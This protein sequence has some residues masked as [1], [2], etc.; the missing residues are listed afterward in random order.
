MRHWLFGMCA[1]LGGGAAQGQPTG[2]TYAKVGH[3][4]ISAGDEKQCSMTQEFGSI[5]E[6]DVQVV[7]VVYDA[8][9]E[10]VVL[11][12]AGKRPKYLL[13]SGSVNLDLGF[14][15]DPA[16]TETWSSKR[17][18]Y[19]KSGSTYYLHHVVMGR[20]DAE[21]ILRDIATNEIIALFLGPSMIMSL[22]L[23]AA[24]AVAKLRECS[25]SAGRAL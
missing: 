13:S 1:L 6:E 16:T 7:G 25:A 12:W 24:E 19:K 11:S 17:F 21:T 5:V 4:E 10:A 14:M 8:K 3:W 22:P 18:D 2:G 9:R 15:N 23:G 20:T